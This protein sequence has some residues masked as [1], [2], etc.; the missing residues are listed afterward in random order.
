[1]AAGVLKQLQSNG[2]RREVFLDFVPAAARQGLAGELSL[3][4]VSSEFIAE[5]SAALSGP[6]L[7]VT[8]PGGPLM[9]AIF[10]AAKH[11]DAALAINIP[12]QLRAANPNAG[13]AVAELIFEIA[14]DVDF[15]R[16]F[17]L[18]SSGWPLV[19]F[20]GSSPEEALKPIFDAV[21]AGYTSIALR[22]ADVDNG[23]QSVLRVLEPVKSFGVGVELE[24]E[25]GVDPAFLLAQLEDA[26][27]QVAAI[28]GAGEFDDLCGGILAVDPAYDAIPTE[29]PFRLG[30]EGFVIEGAVHALRG[31]FPAERLAAAAKDYGPRRALCAF[32][33]ALE[34]LPE[35][36]LDR[37][38]SQVYARLLD[39]ATRVGA[40]G[41]AS[42]LLDAVLADE[43][44]G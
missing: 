34:D 44:R 42:D 33:G 31:E 18:V 4:V 19:D 20:A 15:D 30:I 28:R 5:F 24:F 35:P 3:P 21:D 14:A 38:E 9:A 29:C 37:M 10:R 40:E 17:V 41:T 26:G 23:A 32:A 12:P 13:R 43:E 27:V 1:M 36:V 8:W 39:V 7:E 25:A 22:A 6:I 16:P 11:R 2:P